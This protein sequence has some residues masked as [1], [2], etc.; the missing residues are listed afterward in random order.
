MQPAK[1]S[2]FT[3]FLIAVFVSTAFAESDVFEITFKNFEDPDDSLL[4][5][6]PWHYS[7]E[8]LRNGNEPNL[9]D[10]NWPTLS[11]TRDLPSGWTGKG[12]YRLHLY[13]DP[14]L[15]NKTVAFNLRHAGD[16]RVYLDGTQ[17]YQFH[18]KG[19]KLER[20]P[21]SIRFDQNPNHLLAVFYSNADPQF[22]LSKNLRAGFYITLKDYGMAEK[23]MAGSIYHFVFLCGIL[24]AFSL[25][26]IFIFFSD[27]TQK[28]HLLFALF[29]FFIGILIFT[30]VEDVAVDR[31]E[32][33]YL[34]RL[35]C[36]CQILLNIT[37]V[38]F[39]YMLFGI[40]PRRYYFYV[41]AGV[42]LLIWSWN[43]VSGGWSNPAGASNYISLHTLIGMVEIIRIF[44]TRRTQHERILVWGATPVVLTAIYQMFINFGLVSPFTVL[45]DYVSLPYYAFLIL[46]LTMSIYLS[47]NIAR[48]NRDLKQ[49]V[50]TIQELSEQKLEQE[51][52]A[53]AEEI[54]RKLLEADHRRKTE[55]LEE[56]RRLQLSMLPETV[57]KIPGLEIAFYMKTATEV[58]GDYY[59]F[60][61]ANGC[62]TLVIGDAT[63]HGAQAGIMVTAVK[64]LF[65][66]LAPNPDIQFILSQINDA[67]KAMKLG[68][69]FMAL[70]IAKYSDQLLQVACAGMPPVFLCRSGQPT[71]VLNVRG[72]P[73]GLKPFKYSIL[74]HRLNTG[75][76][77]VFMS[78]GFPEAFNHQKEILGYG[79]IPEILNGQAEKSPNEIIHHLVE[80]AHK[81]SDGAP[82]EDDITFLVLKVV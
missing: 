65:L 55:E 34:L 9:S 11:E 43:R 3:I 32:V 47:R 30:E 15:R 12:W 22:M 27:R 4:L 46:A 19:I 56:A 40:L 80:T 50:I 35:W 20:N 23:Y 1:A 69:M 31:T 78:D 16:L 53:R 25:I 2:V 52:R 24:F 28:L 17:L 62:L 21:F 51:R 13:V 48:A 26:H 73:L 8:D 77:I 29:S 44:L 76:A 33:L 57:P 64:G 39:T 66:N 71:E 63:G 41:A 60:H 61:Y 79:R 42:V 58:G 81:W 67:L 5:K 38:R 68:R 74:Q 14:K 6:G 72:I 7:L 70:S 59:D 36:V 82:Q 10:A 37:V 54:E 75:D 18:T 49:Q 45:L